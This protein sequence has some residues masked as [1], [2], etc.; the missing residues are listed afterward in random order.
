MLTQVSTMNATMTARLVTTGLARNHRTATG[1]AHASS[2]P[3]NTSHVHSAANR[4]GKA[5]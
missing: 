2:T 3:T 5:N 1:S 4:R